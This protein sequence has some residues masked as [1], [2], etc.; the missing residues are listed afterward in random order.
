[1]GVKTKKEKRIKKVKN[2]CRN[3]IRKFLHLIIKHNEKEEE[4]ICTPNHRFY[5]EEKGWTEAFKILSII[6]TILSNSGDYL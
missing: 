2:I 1:M 4:I 6:T 5:I 3:K